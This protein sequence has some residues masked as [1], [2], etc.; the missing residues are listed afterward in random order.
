MAHEIHKQ[1]NG[2][3]CIFSSVV[4]NIVFYD[5]TKEDLIDFY[6]ERERELITK[7]INETTEKLDKGK[8]VSFWSCEN[9][10]EVLK[11]VRSV[12]GRKEANKVKKVLGL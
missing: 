1:P 10:G 11:A 9:L 5:A 8:K 4:D 6:S 7:R 12:H 3:Y 2:R